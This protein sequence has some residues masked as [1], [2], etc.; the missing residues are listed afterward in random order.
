MTRFRTLLPP[1]LLL[2]AVAFGSPSAQSQDAPLTLGGN[3]ELAQRAD[4][5]DDERGRRGIPMERGGFNNKDKNK[6]KAQNRERKREDARQE[7]QPEKEPE[8]KKASEP[9]PREAPARQAPSQRKQQE[10]ERAR[11]DQ[12]QRRQDGERARR[13]NDAKQR[14][15]DAEQSRDRGPRRDDERVRQDAEKLKAE[16]ARREAEKRRQAEEQKAREKSARERQD[17]E[18]RRRDADRARPDDSRRKKEAER[19]NVGR[20]GNRARQEGREPRKFDRG[21]AD[22][23][24]ERARR[25][26]EQKGGG[27]GPAEAFRPAEAKRFEELRKGRKTREVGSREI[28]T[29]PDRRTI[30]RDEKRTIIRHDESAR[31][32]R[33]GREMRRE[34]RKDGLWTVITAGLAGAMIY[35][36]LDDDGRVIRRSRRDR[37]GREYV[38]FDDRRHYRGGHRG[39]DYRPAYIDLPPPVISIPRDRYIVDYEQASY[40]DIYDALS[41]PPVERLDRGYSLDEVRYNYRILERMRRVDLDAINFAFGSWEVGSDQYP[42]L[43]RMARA[44]HRVLDRSPNELF[45]IE[46]HTDAVGSDID[47]LSLSDRRA[48]MVAAILTDTFEVPPENLTTQGYGE[49]YLKDLTDG[50]SRIN[51]RVAVRRITPLLAREGWDD[52]M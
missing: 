31:F 2:S 28:I 38:L 25:E 11:Q 32:T 24:F 29:E 8:K 36:I 35:S 34:K 15:R 51:R 42:K 10:P 27:K 52:P 19:D 18:Q 5:R 4:N 7:R 40:D 39:P 16:E 13:D 22:Q 12:P 44:M 20:D 1:S 30:V 49:E 33:K 6:D 3:V 9:T 17:S 37:D 23:E 50:P 26:A 41:A 43:E 14:P 21:R 46:G 47:N 48:E 45:L